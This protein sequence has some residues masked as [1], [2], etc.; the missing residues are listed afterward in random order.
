MTFERLICLT[1]DYAYLCRGLC[2]AQ[3]VTYHI[4][5]AHSFCIPRFGFPCIVYEYIGVRMNLRDL[6]IIVDNLA[7]IL[8]VNPLRTLHLAV[9]S[10]DQPAE[11]LPRASN[12]FSL[13]QAAAFKGCCTCILARFTPS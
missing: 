8:T 13:P 12:E 2:V 6:A 4:K 7:H 3:H 10:T 11:K 1:T 9:R 5:S